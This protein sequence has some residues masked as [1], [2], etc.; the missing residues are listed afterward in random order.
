MRLESRDLISRT[1]EG[2]ARRLVLACSAVLV[3]KV[4]GLQVKGEDY[5]SPAISEI[6]FGQVMGLAIV[7]MALSHVVHWSADYVLYTNWFKTARV[8]KEDSDSQGSLNGTEVT[9]TSVIDR[10]DSIPEKFENVVDHVNRCRSEID[11]L[12]DSDRANAFGARIAKLEGDYRALEGKCYVVESDLK[13]LIKFSQ[14][15]DPGFRKADFTSKFVIF[16]WF[17]AVPLFVAVLAFFSLLPFAVGFLACLR[18][19]LGV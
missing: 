13:D 17:L 4:Y 11:R 15:L 7:F 2:S 19:F 10:L 8:T 14:Q 16:G 9:I 1:T 3:L 12:K 18:R 5:L 6:V